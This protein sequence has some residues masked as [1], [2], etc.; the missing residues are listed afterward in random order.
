MSKLSILGLRMKEHNLARGCRKTSLFSVHSVSHICSFVKNARS[1]IIQDDKI[2][3][4]YLRSDAMC[5]V[6]INASF[7]DQIERSVSCLNLNLQ[8]YNA[9][10]Q[11]STKR[12]IG[13]KRAYSHIAFYPKSLDQI[14]D[15]CSLQLKEYLE[16]R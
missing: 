12:M 9:F 11:S 6:N 4:V 1:D 3:P 15:L 8:I 10:I 7:K 2:R 5:S 13:A 14:I 16:G